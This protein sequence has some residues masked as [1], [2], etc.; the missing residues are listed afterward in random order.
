[1]LCQ[2]IGK[3]GKI[4]EVNI[5]MYKLLFMLNDNKN[6]YDNVKFYT[7]KLIDYLTLPYPT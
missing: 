2:I 3:D 5:P 7:Y 1:M 6:I 4:K